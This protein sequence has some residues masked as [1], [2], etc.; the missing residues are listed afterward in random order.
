MIYTDFNQQKP[1]WQKH[2]RSKHDKYF[3]VN[4]NVVHMEHKKVSMYKL[5]VLIDTTIMHQ[6]TYM[7]I[8]MVY[9]KHIHS[10]ILKINR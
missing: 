3:Q 8:K 4:T 7:I 10:M 5:Y 1:E 9:P 6:D 2:A